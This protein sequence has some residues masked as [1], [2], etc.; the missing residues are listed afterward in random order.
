MNILYLHGLDSKLSAPK[1]EILEKFGQVFAPDLNYYKDPNS[2]ATILGLYPH[3]NL[4]AVVGSSMGGFAGY[5]V[6]NILKKPA[7]LFNPALKRRS[8]SQNIPLNFEGYSN[9]NQ[10]VIGQQDDVVIPGETFQFLTENFNPVTDIQLHL[11]PKLT[12]NIPVEFFEQEV[13]TF[14]S[15][16]DTL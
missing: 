7:L 14:F 9:Y 3:K 6:S 4:N 16:L 8:V 5:Y 2:I 11:V 13:A 1:R 10:I 12:H 15:K